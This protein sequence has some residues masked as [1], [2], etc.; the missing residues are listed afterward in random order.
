M[1]NVR[2]KEISVYAKTASKRRKRGKTHTIL[3]QTEKYH[4]LHPLLKN[5]QIGVGQKNLTCFKSTLSPAQMKEGVILSKL[6][7]VPILLKS[8]KNCKLA[9][10]F[11]FTGVKI[12][13]LLR[14]CRCAS[15]FSVT[16]LFFIRF[17]E[18]R[19]SIMYKSEG[20][21]VHVVVT[22]QVTRVSLVTVTHYA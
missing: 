20:I 1:K 19:Y 13:I 8:D 18:S 6:S 2:I 11:S 14:N 12:L 17:L 10:N 21:S 7:L 5:L 3:D 16:L 4:W 9:V 15:F 22:I